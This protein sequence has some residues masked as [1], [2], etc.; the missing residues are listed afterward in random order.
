MFTSLLLTTAVAS[1]QPPAA[2]YYP[3][4]ALPARPMPVQVQ[5]APRGAYP[6]IQQ[7][8][9]GT[10]PMAAP[11]AQPTP[12]PMPMNGK[13]DFPGNEAP[14]ESKEE[15]EAAEDDGPTKY[16]LE[17]TL[18]GT[19]FGEILNNRGIRIY[20]WTEGSYNLSTASGSNA[21]VF[22]NDRANEF[23]MNQNY[24][25]IEK[26]IDSSKDEFQL[27]WRLDTILPGTDAR[28]TLPRGLWNN[29]LRSNNGGPE[30]YVFDPF[31]FYAEAYLPGLGNGTS[32]K[33]GRFAT[34]VGYELVQAVDT[35][36]VSRSYM[37]QYNPFT[38]TGAY[39]TTSLGDNWTVGYGLSTGTDTFIQGSTNRLNF[40]GQLK[41]APKDG[42]TSIA[43]NT[44]VTN[45]EYIADQ[46]FFQYNF[47]NVV[48]THNLSEDLTYVLDAGYAH[49]DG[50]V[51]ADGTP[52]GFVNWYGAA[53][54][55]TL[56]H[57]D[58]LASTLRAEVFDD[59]QGVRT[60]FKG[61]YTEVTYGLAWKPCPGVIVRPY[62]RYDNNNRTEVWEG[63]QNLFTSGLDMIF[64][65]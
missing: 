32:V 60:G 25:V 8:P 24:V 23:V 39:A 47:Y 10:L 52:V 53:N 43:F 40:L 12:M 61:L 35:P 15:K 59:A 28:T 55:L 54:Y 48:L 29:Q 42:D 36:F 22:M 1:G 49:M 16:L 20:G 4:G 3:P 26:A 51:A 9:P 41:W 33:V 30:L 56:A 64:R 13:T 45:P 50:Y 46:S 57:S 18:E 5:A 34:H 2:G 6:V 37:F 31:Q 11:G 17:R 63:N 44:V 38:H 21:P 62:A 65:W 27:G 58:N 19:R 14:A 7:V